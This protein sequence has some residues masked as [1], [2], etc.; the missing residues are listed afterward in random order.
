MATSHEKLAASLQILRSFQNRGA[1]AMRSRDLTRTHRER[2]TKNGFLQE[3]F[4]GWYL[5]AH[6]CPGK[7]QRHAEHLAVCPFSPEPAVNAGK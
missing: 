2:L 4:K 1:V 7:R 6:G 3:I 5:I